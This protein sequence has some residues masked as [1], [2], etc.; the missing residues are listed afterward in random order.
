MPTWMRV[1]ASLGGVL[2]TIMTALLVQNLLEQ[3][4]RI[5]LLGIIGVLSF[6]LVWVM[7]APV[8]PRHRSLD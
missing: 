6:L 7:T 4:T 8:V 1:L 3:P 2:M 5:I